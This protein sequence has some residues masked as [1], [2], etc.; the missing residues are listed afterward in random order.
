VKYN[1]FK[2]LGDLEGKISIASSREIKKS[3]V[4]AGISDSAFL[5]IAVF[6]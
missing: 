5:H 1:T 6:N 2:V 3:C 4:V